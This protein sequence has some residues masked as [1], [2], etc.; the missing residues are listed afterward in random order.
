MLYSACIVNLKKKLIEKILDVVVKLRSAIQSTPFVGTSSRG[1]VPI[2][3]IAD[4]RG[5]SRYL[6]M[7]NRR[8]ATLWERSRRGR[9]GLVVTHIW[10]FSLK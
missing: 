5:L 3:F 10:L 6:S 1:P 9:R 4:D 2:P 8:G 7:V